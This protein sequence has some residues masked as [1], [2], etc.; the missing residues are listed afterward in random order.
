MKLKKVRSQSSVLIPQSSIIFLSS[1]SQIFWLKNILIFSQLYHIMASLGHSME[2]LLYLFWIWPY[3]N[4]CNSP[5]RLSIIGYSMV[6]SKGRKEEEIPKECKSS[7]M[8]HIFSLCNT[9]SFIFSRCIK[10][11]KSGP[12]FAYHRTCHYARIN[13]I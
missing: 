5:V 11:T 13:G 8:S 6:L 9:W 10:T 4:T 7:F 2:F 12:I 3:S 1:Q